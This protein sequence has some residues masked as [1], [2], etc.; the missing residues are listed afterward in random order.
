MLHI[1]IVFY[2]M[3]IN[4]KFVR[5]ALF[6]FYLNILT[7]DLYTFDKLLFFLFCILNM[8]FKY[9]GMYIFWLW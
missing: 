2:I 8:I 6:V 7:S 4:T 5:K 9:P 1:F 3:F